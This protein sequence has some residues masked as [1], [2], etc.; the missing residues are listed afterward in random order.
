MRVAY[1]SPLPPRKSGIADFSAELLPHLSRYLE[2]EVFVEDP[3]AAGGQP[4]PVRRFGE[5]R[6][7]DFDLPLYQIGNNADHVF[8]YETALRHPGVVVMH[9]FNLHHLIAEATIRRNDWDAYLREAEYN[10]GEKA[11]AYARRVRALEAGPDYENLPMNRRL[12]EASR[13]LIVLNRFVETQVR[14]AGY[15]P[16]VAVIPHGAAMPESRRQAYRRR[17]GLDETTPLV[18]IFGFLKPYKRI[19]EALHAL[20]RLAK[21]Q[22]GVRMILVGEEHPD[23]PVRR[24]IES[25]GLEDHVRVLGY[26]PI[27]DF[28]GYMSA[29][30]ICL[31]LRYPTAGESSGPLLRALGLGRPVLVSDIGSFAELPDDVCLKVPVDGREIDFIFEYLNLLVSRPELARALGERAKKYV[32]ERC[33][34]ERVAPQY[35]AFLK[36]VAEGRGW[37]EPPGAVERETPKVAVCSSAMMSG[38]V[39]AEPAPARP[40]EPSPENTHPWAEYILGY[41]GDSEE[42]RNYI[43]AHLTRLVRTLEITPRGGPQDRILEMGAYMQITPALKNLL[44]YG[45]VRGS[46][47]GPPGR[48]DRR[49]ARSA[50]GECFCCLIDHFNAEKDRFPYEDDFFATVLCCELLE[51]L[52]DDPMHM[53][54][55]INRI[56]RPGGSLVLTTPNICSL[57]AIEAILMA[58][59]PGFFH[60]YIRPAAGGE[61]APR[62]S[63]EYAPRDVNL[64]FEEAGFE[65]TLFETGPYRAEP[66]AAGE[67]VLHLLDRY[68]LPKEMRGEAIYAVGRKIGPVRNRY[69]ESLYA[70]EDG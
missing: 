64:L 15:K 29:V 24:L 6:P 20:Q 68:E 45:E 69:P 61:A 54:S 62:H 13:A 16:P 32:K 19:A 53:M 52:Y 4:L 36:A 43:R 41:A 1:F 18:G 10:G 12:L 8:V 40:A 48:V 50:S 33:A 2:L 42:R 27:E 34:W 38:R 46:Y 58:Y 70:G 7:S 26:V 25:L 23:F 9:E 57:R 30:D 49:E 56:L 39:E 60:Q 44:G 3:P 51:H 63:R 67:W 35:A 37:K 14:A 65:I 28:Q 21:V 5:Y 17:L 31:S 55:E 22:P 66:S 47:L 11:L 59:H